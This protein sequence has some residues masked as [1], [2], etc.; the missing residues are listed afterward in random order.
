MATSLLKGWLDDRARP[1]CWIDFDAYARRVFAGD[2]PDWYRDPARHAATLIQARGVLPTQVVT[3]DVVAPFLE[4]VDE[5]TAGGLVSALGAAAPRTFVGDVLNALLHRFAGKVDVALKL[6]APW[7]LLG[8]AE[9]APDFDALDD[10]ATALAGCMRD[11]ADRPLAGLVI[12]TLRGDALSDDEIDAYQPLVNAARHYGW[13][14]A[15]ALP[16]DDTGGACDVELDLDV[17]LWPARA[18][19]SLDASARPVQG[20]GLTTDFWRGAVQ[21]ADGAGL[22]YGTV[23][24]DAV[25]ETVVSVARALQA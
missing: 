24:A 22:Y 7:D 16:G 5:R 11:L 2:P 13:W 18:A 15:L 21:L 12:E 1:F 6:R 25:P 10:V 4:L 19:D 3:V 9:G 20:G 8:G 14:T 23:P 17:V